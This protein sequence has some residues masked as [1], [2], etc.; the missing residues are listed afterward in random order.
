MQD[1]LRVE[2]AKTY[3]TKAGLP[4]GDIITDAGLPVGDDSPEA[5]L[6]KGDDVTDAGLPVGDDRS[7]EDFLEW[8]RSI[9]NMYSPV[10]PSNANMFSQ[11][12]RGLSAIQMAHA[13]CGDRP[14]EQ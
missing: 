11:F 2:E 9:R 13:A 14:T 10:K 4:V 7:V 5:G 3:V 1:Y 12:G 8:I 6:P